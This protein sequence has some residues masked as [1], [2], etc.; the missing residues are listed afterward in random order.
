[1]TGRR[2]RGKNEAHTAIDY[3][4]Y[5]PQGTEVHQILS[6]EWTLHGMEEA[7]S[8][9][10][11]GACWVGRHHRRRED[12]LLS[13]HMACLPFFLGS[14]RCGSGV[15]ESEERTAGPKA[16]ASP[17]ARG[18]KPKLLMPWV[19]EQGW[20]RL[21]WPLSSERR[22]AALSAHSHWSSIQGGIS[23]L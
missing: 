20:Y 21:L 7:W 18:R 2:G 16:R 8:L 22:G 13:I 6:R 12:R 17:R 3:S 10:V 1:M 5:I 15:F 4:S 23:K 14:S 11:P 19:N 9:R